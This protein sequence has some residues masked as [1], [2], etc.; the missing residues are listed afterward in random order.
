MD[1]TE[2][3]SGKWKVSFESWPQWIRRRIDES[4]DFFSDH[5]TVFLLFSWTVGMLFYVLHIAH[6]DPD[7]EL[8]G[9][10]RE[11]TAGVIGAL[12]GMLTGMKV[13]AEAQKRKDESN[14]KS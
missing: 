13:G 11:V 9:W 6:H 8:L 7:K 10:A 12:L 4:W 3:R 1:I 2:P 14:N 5:F